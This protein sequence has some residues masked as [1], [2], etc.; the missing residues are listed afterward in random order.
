VDLI[1]HVSAYFER[2]LKIQGADEISLDDVQHA[3]SELFVDWLY[4]GGELPSSITS[5]NITE[6]FQAIV[7]G[8]TYMAPLFHATVYNATVTFLVDRKLVPS[9][10]DITYVFEKLPKD[11]ALRELLVELVYLRSAEGTSGL[12]EE[13]VKMVEGK[14]EERGVVLEWPELDAC[15]CM[16]MGVRR[17]AWGV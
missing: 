7:F 15:E 14:V 11:H 6:M 9:A 8:N 3:T 16:F 5:L 10:E 4:T 13:L 2:A 17:S 12:P 1:S